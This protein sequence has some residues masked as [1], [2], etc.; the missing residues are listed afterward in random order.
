[1]EPN[2]LVFLQAPQ[3]VLLAQFN[4]GRKHGSKMPHPTDMEALSHHT[5]NS[6]GTEIISGQPGVVDLQEDIGVVHSGCKDL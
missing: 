3:G 4:A 2:S 6:L 1:M 5:K